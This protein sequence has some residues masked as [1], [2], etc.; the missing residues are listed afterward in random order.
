MLIKYQSLKKRNPFKYFTGYNYNDDIRPL[1]IIFPQT[2]RYVKCFE[3]NKA[4]FFKI[5]GNKLLNKKTQIWKKVKSLLNIKFDSE[6]VHGHNDT[7]IK[8]KMK[9]Y[10]NNVNPN[11]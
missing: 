8:A 9:I 10:D 4:M 11:F 6:P 1:C 2:I 3:S 7:Y 5:S